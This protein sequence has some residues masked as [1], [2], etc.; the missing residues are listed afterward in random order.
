MNNWFNSALK[1]AGGT[2]SNLGK[3]ISET[4]SDLVKTV[5]GWLPFSDEDTLA[6]FAVL[7]AVAAADGEIGEDELSMIFSSPDVDKLSV[8]GKKKLQT[9]SCNP[10]SL[11]EAIEKL[12]K[13]NQELKFGLIFYILNLVWVDGVMTLGETE[14]IKIARQKLEINAV[15]VEAIEKF[16][17][18]LAKVRNEQSQE[19]LEEVK[20]ATERMKKVGVPIG[21]LVHSQK[22]PEKMEYSDDKFWEKMRE[23]G[24]QAG[25]G[26]VEQAF[27]MWYIMHDSNIPTQA[28][29]IVGGALAY[30]ILPV[31]MVPDILPVVGFTDD[32]PI[33]GS[34]FAS[35]AMNITPDIIANARQQTEA[36]FAGKAVLEGEIIDINSKN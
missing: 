7:F 26:L 14:A 8:E 19:A 36:L 28:K 33:I 35:I 30:W 4:T 3:N 5:Q 29:L 13:A 34:A 21:A 27:T 10:P 15:Q 9:Y 16:I 1:A 25:K 24:L 32:L 20:A 2:A 22:E 31:D 11:E 17:K 6:F 18:L 23:F 12:S